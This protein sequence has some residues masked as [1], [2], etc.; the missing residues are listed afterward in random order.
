M[1]WRATFVLAALAGVALMLR[2]APAQAPVGIDDLQERAIKAAV[3]RVAP[4]IVQIETQGGTDIISTG[5]RGG[6]IRKAAGPTTGVIVSPDGHIISSAFNFVNKPSAIYVRVPGHKE[7]YVARAVANDKTRMLTLIKIEAVGLAV[8]AAAPKA[9]VKIGQTAIALGRTLDPNPDNLPSVSV[10]IISALHRIWGKAL[11]TDAKVSP[12]NYGGPLVD[13]YGRVLG[14]LIPAS[15][16]SDGETAGVEWYDSGIGFAI[17]LEDV[18][19]VLSRLKAGKDL[20]RGLLGITVQ[21][22]DIYGPPP[23]IAAVAPES[24]AAKAGIQPGDVVT[25]LDGKPVRNQA[26]VLH[27]LGTKYEGDNVTVKVKR[28]KEEKTFVNLRLG[29]AVNAYGRTILGILPMRDDPEPGIEVRYVYPKGPADAA[30]LKA[31]DRIMKIG[32]GMGP[33]QPFSGR[34]QML[35]ILSRATPGAK[36]K[37]EVV[38]K[39]N[40]KTETV[41]ATL[42][43]V[44][45]KGAVDEVPDTLPEEASKKKALEPRKPAGGPGP[46][47]GPRPGPRPM[48]PKPA[49]APPPAPAP[50]KDDKKA[51]TGLIQRKTPDGSHSYWIYVPRDYDPNISYALVLWLHPVGKGKEKDIDDFLDLWI[52]YCREKRIIVAGAIAENDTGWVPSESD[53]IANVGRE[54]LANYTVDRSRVVVHGMGVG[55]QM[56]FYMAFHNRDLVRGVAVTGA[57]MSNQPKEKAPGQPVSFF[58]HVGEKDPLAEAVSD[59]KDKLIEHKYPVVHREEKDAGHQYLGDAALDELIRWIDSLDRL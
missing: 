19:A 36:V 28:G 40:K 37:L 47:P 31:G 12:T 51:E 15:P 59:S 22:R 11:Q 9:D 20:N 32:A 43:E 18:N 7:R 14:I 21:S 46:M 26:Q 38:R 25:E 33:L 10:G 55:G 57:A 42:G 6:L 50:K 16:Q 48:P 13:I 2:L 56:A 1:Y 52:S 17:P 3:R 35:A 49:P 54:I 30:G 24:A 8:P 34:E 23:T 44:P 5:P 29:S 58:L 4:S 27:A 45:S 41:E 53:V 39:E